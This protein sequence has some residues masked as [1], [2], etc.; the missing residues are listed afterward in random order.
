MGRWIP[1]YRS[2]STFADRGRE[3]EPFAGQQGSADTAFTHSVLV[4]KTPTRGP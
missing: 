3:N 4:S 1:F 2:F